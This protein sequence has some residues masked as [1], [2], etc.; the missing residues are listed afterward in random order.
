MARIKKKKNGNGQQAPA[1][2]KQTGH[3]G[4]QSIINQIDKQTVNEKQPTIVSNGNDKG[5]A[6]SIGRDKDKQAS[7]ASNKN[8]EANYEEQTNKSSNQLEME[9]L[10]PN[11]SK[12]VITSIPHTVNIHAM[13]TSDIKQKVVQESVSRKTKESEEVYMEDCEEGK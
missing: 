3:K 5:N 10:I 11:T 13:G 9:E 2:N 7:A 4:Q 8:T 6:K 12:Q 1:S